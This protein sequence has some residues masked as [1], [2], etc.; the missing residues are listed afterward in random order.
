MTTKRLNDL[1]DKFAKGEGDLQDLGEIM[2]DFYLAMS[3]V[4]TELKTQNKE[5]KAN[6]EVIYEDIQNIKKFLN[7][8]FTIIQED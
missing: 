4:I 8:V 7:P 6:Q 3:K 1:K 2:S 5:I